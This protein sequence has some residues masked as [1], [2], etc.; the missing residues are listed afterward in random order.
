MSRWQSG[1]SFK[2]ALEEARLAHYAEIGSNPRLTKEAVVGQLYVLASRL[3]SDRED[4]KASDALL[5]LAKVQG[6]MGAEPDSLWTTFSK[7]S[8]AELDEVRR[9]LREQQ[10]AQATAPVEQDPQGSLN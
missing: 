10:A 3:A 7:L 4:Y 6:W 9:R 1:H 2:E 8:Q 5:K